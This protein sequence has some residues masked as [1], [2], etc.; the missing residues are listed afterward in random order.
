[1]QACNGD[2]EYACLRAFRENVGIRSIADIRYFAES[3]E[4][5]ENDPNN[6][7]LYIWGY[8]MNLYD[9]YE[10]HG[11]VITSGD[12]WITYGEPGVFPRIEL[13][14]Y[15]YED[16]I[17]FKYSVIKEDN[18]EEYYY[19]PDGEPLI[20]NE[21]YVVFVTEKRHGGGTTCEERQVLDLENEICRTVQFSTDP[22]KPSVKFET[23]YDEP[24]IF[25]IEGYYD[26][27]CEPL[28]VLDGPWNEHAFV[29]EDCQGTEGDC[30]S[31]WAE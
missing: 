23:C 6:Y 31:P 11:S 25:S 21:D 29:R 9:Y 14:W 3:F 17:M 10:A 30:A 2:D 19:G 1:M 22:S 16:P 12:W 18:P 24:D 8:V 27:E 26:S 15:P 5:Y 28:A 7:S 20:S 13:T 4:K